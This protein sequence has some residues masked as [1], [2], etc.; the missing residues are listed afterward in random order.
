MHKVVCAQC[1]QLL[2]RASHI[3]LFPD[4]G[5]AEFVLNVVVIDSG[6]I[7]TTGRFFWTHLCVEVPV[8]A[9]TIMAIATSGQPLQHPNNVSH[10][11]SLV[12]TVFFAGLTFAWLYLI[13]PRFA[14]HTSAKGGMP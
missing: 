6:M 13:L 4:A 3:S 7:Y 8:A 1:V 11:V 9:A 12:A 2:A 5:A 14:V 10:L